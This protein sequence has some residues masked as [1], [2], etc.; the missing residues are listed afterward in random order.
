MLTR[1]SMACLVVVLA[2]A[3]GCGSSSRADATPSADAT[4]AGDGVP[5]EVA[6]QQPPPPVGRVTADVL[7]AGVQLGWLASPDVRYR[8]L[9]RENSGRATS[10]ALEQAGSAGQAEYLDETARTGATYE[11]RIVPENLWGVPG[12]PSAWVTARVGRG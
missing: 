3:A 6:K 2:A 5:V 10:I 7:A 9:R 12:E 8:I 11:Y 1:A 4:P